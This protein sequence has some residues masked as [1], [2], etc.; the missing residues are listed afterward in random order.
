MC[1]LTMRKIEKLL[2][3]KEAQVNPITDSTV[4]IQTTSHSIPSTPC[5]F[6]EVVIIA[7]YLRRIGALTKIA[8][9]VRFARRRFGHYEVIDFLAMLFG[10]AVSGERTDGGSST[11]GCSPLLNPS[12]PYLSAIDSP[13]VRRSRAF[14]P[15]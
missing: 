3:G 5:W 12:W 2:T 1:L 4:T 15:H 7:Q 9:R 8:E 10:Y 6:G 13:L 14:W 11:S